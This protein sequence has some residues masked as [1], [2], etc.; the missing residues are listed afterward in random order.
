MFS[1]T[2]KR[3][4]ICFNRKN[5]LGTRLFSLLEILCFYQSIGTLLCMVGFWIARRVGWDAPPF[6]ASAI[7]RD[8]PPWFSPVK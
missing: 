8:A 1:G 7:A 4:G 2:R 6:F 5:Q 3:L